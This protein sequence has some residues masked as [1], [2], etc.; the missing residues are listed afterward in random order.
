VEVEDTGIGIAT[1]KIAHLFEPFSQADSSTTRKYGGTGLGLAICSRLVSIMGGEMSVTSTPGKGSCFSFF[2]PLV[3]AERPADPEAAKAREIL[4]SEPGNAPTLRILVAED[5]AINRKVISRMLQGLGYTSDMVA[6]GYECLEAFETKDYD[7][8]FMDVQMPEL[9]GFETTSR[10]RAAGKGVWISALTA[11][12]MPD[13]QLKCQIAGM[14][15][16]MTKPFKKEQLQGV[17]E[18]FLAARRHSEG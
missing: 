18:R 14:N 6:N 16:Y 9:D 17:I 10:L 8:V 3:E 13:D 7:L 2:I 12:A 11:A 1:E 4:A 5:N 15:D